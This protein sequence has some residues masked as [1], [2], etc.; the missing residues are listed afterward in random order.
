M[1]IV[2]L[3]NTYL[4]HVGGVARSVDAFCREYRK[5]GH[6]VLVVAPEFSQKI[7][8]EKDVVRIHAIQNFNGSDFSVAL[9]L[10]GE[11]TEQ[12]DFFEPDLVHSHHPF[13]LGMSALRIARSRELPLVFTHHTLYER[14]THYVPADSEALKRFVIEL[15]T[16]YSNLASMVFAPSESVADLLR[17]R[18]V[19]SPIRV[20]PTGVK[21]ED[22]QNGD[23]AAAR[24]QYGIPEQ[25]FVIGHLGRLAAEKNLEFLSEAVLELINRNDNIH[26]L[27]VGTGPMQSR[28]EELFNA[29]GKGDR[30][31]LTGTLQGEAQRDAYSAM[32]VFGFS[33]TSETQGMVLTEAMAAGVPVVALDASGCRE[34]V[35]DRI[36]GRLV[37][38]HCQRE[39]IAAL[40]W[41]LDLSREEYQSLCAA[42]LDTAERFSM[43]NC[44]SAALDHYETLVHQHWPLDDSLYAQWMRLRNMIGA[45]WEILE[46]VTSA[47][48][49]AL[50]PDHSGKSSS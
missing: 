34:V 42:A 11:L 30:L 38:K 39:M 31:H 49:A 10:S 28:M 43:E 21:L 4:P 2:M 47:A 24:A 35:E 13:L 37:L 3:T 18:G 9:P 41:V 14:Y 20:V 27:V 29:H 5:R 16:R 26:F 7:E 12:L 50:D 45:Q 25:A 17:E 23:G 8:N 48:S 44:A 6:R 33:S 32:N 1:N 40:Q 22:Y 15:A 36:N 46:G 19:K